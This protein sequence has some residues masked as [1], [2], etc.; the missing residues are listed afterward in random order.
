MPEVFKNAPLRST[1]FQLR[2]AGE[3]A[4]ETARPRIQEAVRAE[5][6][7]LYVPKVIPDV[8]LAL[9]PYVF[10]SADETEAMEIALNTMSYTTTHYEGY[11]NFK[12]RALH[13]VGHFRE[14][15]PQVEELNRVGLRYVNHIRFLRETKQSAI[16]LNDFLNVHLGLPTGIPASLTEINTVFGVDMGEGK[17]RVA[18]RHERDDDSLRDERLVLDFDFAQGPGLE[19]D[20]IE[21]YLERAHAHTKQIF[22]DLI[23]ERYLPVIRG[24]E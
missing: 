20:K 9:Q 18:I 15:V 13:F 3:T 22:V 2:F 23:S 8:P 19:I 24:E 4:I 11:A 16:P 5:L 12:A 14:A 21:E 10:R 7:K 6:P 1:I 17:L